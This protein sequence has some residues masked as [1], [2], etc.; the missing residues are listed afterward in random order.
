MDITVRDRFIF[1]CIKYSKGTPKE[2][3]KECNEA[4]KQA[5]Q[6]SETEW[7]E[8]YKYGKKLREKARKIRR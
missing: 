4:Y 7:N 5:N 1:D 2:K 3:S 6:P 8:L